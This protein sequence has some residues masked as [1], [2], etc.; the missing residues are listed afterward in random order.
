[1][2]YGL[3]LGQFESGRLLAHFLGRQRKL[4]VLRLQECD[5]EGKALFAIITQ[6][7]KSA[8]IRRLEKLFLSLNMLDTQDSIVTLCGLV[9]E[10]KK[11]KW[12]CTF[13]TGVVIK[14]EKD[15]S[16]IVAISE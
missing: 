14:W 7:R 12:L 16:D 8:S 3:N 11:L 4:K 10:A 1:M 5:L 2:L 13:Y 9:K 15:G 6:L